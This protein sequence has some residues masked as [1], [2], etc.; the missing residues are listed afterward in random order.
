M[1][2]NNEVLLR[3]ISSGVNDTVHP[4]QTI[5]IDEADKLFTGPFYCMMAL[6]DSRIDATNCSIGIKE[7]DP[8]AGA[9]RA[10]T[11]SL[12]IPAGMTI[13]SNIESI[14]LQSGVIL[15]YAKPNVTITVQA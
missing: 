1:A 5:L 6:Q 9:L 2:T 7:K 13:H 8:S 10:I 12:V 15:A 3:S 4:G 14:V 11:G